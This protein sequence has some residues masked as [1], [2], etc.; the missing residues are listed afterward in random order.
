M[1]SQLMLRSLRRRH[2]RADSKPWRRAFAPPWAKKK[3]VV[4]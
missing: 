2:L 4:V 1:C 3:R